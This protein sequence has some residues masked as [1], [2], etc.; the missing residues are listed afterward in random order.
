[1]TRGSLRG[2]RRAEVAQR[3][4]H[5]FD[6][7][8]PTVTALA[9]GIERK[10]STVRRL[11]AEGGVQ[12]R[13]LLVGLS[14]QEVTAELARRFEGGEPVQELRRVTGI[15]ERVIRERLR[16]AGAELESRRCRADLAVPVHEL[17]ARY[18]ADETLRELADQSGV[19]FGMV[20]R[21]LLDEGVQLRSRGGRRQRAGSDG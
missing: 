2:R 18:E 15:D 8:R 5:R 19:S 9:A 20:R 13:W 3:L 21:V 14:D 12:S 10:P 16:H 7:E 17:V 11:L 6:T 1:M 4:A